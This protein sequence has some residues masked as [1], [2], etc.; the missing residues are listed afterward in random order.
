[1]SPDI[2]KHDLPVN[3]NDDR[4]LRGR[5]A[6]LK[7]SDVAYAPAFAGILRRAARPGKPAWRRY[8]AALAVLIVAALV[9]ARFESRKS[10]EPETLITE[11]TSPTDF[12]L[13]TPGHEVLEGVPEILQLPML[14]EW[15][16]ATET[17]ATSPTPQRK[18]AS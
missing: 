2:R 11:W 8:V 5:F 10:S 15:P 9:V 1:M 14:D 4:D 12:L 18:K 3:D 17:P 13:E 6:S 7:S 16:G